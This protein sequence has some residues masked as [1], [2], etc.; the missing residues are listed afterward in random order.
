[1]QRSW[2]TSRFKCGRARSWGLRVLWAP[3][4]PKWRDACSAS[5]P[6]HC[7]PRR[8]G[9][10]RSR[11]AGRAASRKSST[12]CG[13]AQ[14]TECVKKTRSCCRRNPYRREARRKPHAQKK[15]PRPPIAG[16]ARDRIAVL[17]APG[18]DKPCDRNRTLRL[19]GRSVKGNEYRQ[20]RLL[21]SALKFGSNPHDP[22]LR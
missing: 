22:E 21:L 12:M 18:P 3:G 19:C 9:S 17:E 7:G 8:L 11:R 14:S 13:S 16:G 20:K 6:A 2:A 1:M 4:E 15:A 5:I 10:S